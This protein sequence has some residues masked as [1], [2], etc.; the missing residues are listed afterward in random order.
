METLYLVTSLFILLAG[1]AFQSGVTAEGSGSHALLTWV[2]AVVLVACVSVFVG[3]LA[4]EVYRSYRFARRAVAAVQRVVQ[5]G[6]RRLSNITPTGA[7]G[8]RLSITTSG[9]AGSLGGFSGGA[10]RP[11]RRESSVASL[12][13]PGVQATVQPTAAFPPAINK[14]PTSEW[15]TNPL[16]VGPRTLFVAKPIAPPVPPVPPPPP[17]PPTLPPPLLLCVPPVPHAP[18]GSSSPL[19]VPGS[20]DPLGHPGTVPVHALVGPP[21]AHLH[22][23]EVMLAIPAILPTSAHARD[24]VCLLSIH[25]RGHCGRHCHCVGPWA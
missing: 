24:S 4:L 18:S 11:V 9:V 10:P 7:T 20:R 15:V 23:I 1:M 12:A 6:R 13:T 3:M 17:P 5:A 8:R 19:V 14:L 2:V 16:R 22:R 21:V 25:R